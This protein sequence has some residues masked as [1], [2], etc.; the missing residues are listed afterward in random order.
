M[1]PKPF[2]V[3]LPLRLP[4]ANRLLDSD[5]NIWGST[6]VRTS[7]GVCHLIFSR[8]P[9]RL[10]F[11]AWATNSEYAYATAP[12]PFG[13]YTVHGR[14]LPPAGDSKRWDSGGCHNPSLIEH[15]GGY[16]LYY[17]GHHGN[18]EWWNHRNNQRVGVA[19]ADHPS[20]PWRLFDEPLMKPRPGHILTTT[21]HV[22]LRLDGQFE[23]VYKTV[24]EGPMPFGG[25]V[26][27]VIALADNPLGPFEDVRD[28]FIS[29]PKSKFPID[30][31]VQ[32]VQE[33]R[34]YA[35]AKDNSGEFVGERRPLIL[36]TSENG[37]DW[38]LGD[39]PVMIRPEITW[40]D[41]T[42]V[43]Y[44]RLE[45]PKILFGDG[46]PVALFLAAL[47]KDADH[48]HSLFVPLGR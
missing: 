7:D 13:P 45:M 28:S 18:G 26:K 14:I 29:T 20:G 11:D 39:N 5:W 8:W 23:M 27:H 12:G 9:R 2:R 42:V 15:N 36:F 17:S 4:Y 46:L 22:F 30:D 33:G 34:Y 35:L 21:P 43:R 25:V 44:E 38:T 10:G 31:H 16:Y 19:V 3:D 40:E 41:D 37:L 32:W 1:V 6:P 24:T 47:P 48:S